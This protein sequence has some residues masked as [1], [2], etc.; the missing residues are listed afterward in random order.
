M[1][2]NDGTM[3]FYHDI[4]ILDSCTMSHELLVQ[5]EGMSIGTPTLSDIDGDG[6]LDLITTDTTGYSGASCSII[7]WS[8]GVEPPES[9]SWGS[10]LGTNNDGI[11]P[12]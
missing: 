2:E 7:R 8:L 3:T 11:F 12:N 6:V 9:I 4:E 10:Y 5:R 1:F